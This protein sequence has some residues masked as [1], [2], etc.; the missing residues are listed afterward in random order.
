MAALSAD[1]VLTHSVHE[2]ALLRRA[3]PGAAVHVVPWAVAGRPV[4][5]DDGA[6]GDGAT[7]D[8]GRNGVAFIANYGH[9]PN[10]DAARFLAEA[11]MPLVWQ[12]DP[13]IACVLAGSRMPPSIHRL[14]L[15]GPS[16][17]L[18]TLGHVPDLETVFDRVRLTVAPLRYGAGVKGKVLASFAAGV[19]CVMSPI[20]AEGIDLPAALAACVG[21]SAAGMA[22][23]ILHLHADAAARR[24]AGRAGLALIET[25][26]SA[27]R[28]TAALRAAIEGRHRRAS[29]AVEPPKQVA[30]G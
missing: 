4:F 10:V 6:S 3:V 19:P 8:V 25:G 23:L 21:A 1:A 14:E 28:V 15:P 13:S 22:D 7:D 16:M 26:F 24:D 11:I 12:R 5:A 30:A 17:A 18:L 29:L 27:S 20:A 9:E 2:A